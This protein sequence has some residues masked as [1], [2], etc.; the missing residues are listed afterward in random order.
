LGDLLLYGLDR[1]G[2]TAFTETLP[3]RDASALRALGDER[4]K[5]F[6]AVEVWD[7]ALCILR[8]R[9]RASEQA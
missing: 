6:H 7:G 5:Q 8:L 9:R 2:E 4:L 1:E 3:R